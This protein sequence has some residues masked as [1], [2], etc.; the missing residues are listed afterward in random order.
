MPKSTP[1]DCA[2]GLSAIPSVRKNWATYTKKRTMWLNKQ[3]LLRNIRTDD[4]PA[5]M[6]LLNSWKRNHP[7]VLHKRLQ[8]GSVLI[9]HWSVNQTLLFWPVILF[10]S[11]TY[12]AVVNLL[13]SVFNV[14]FL[15]TIL[16]PKR[17]E[18]HLECVIRLLWQRTIRTEADKI[19]SPWESVKNRRLRRMGR[20]SWP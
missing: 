16:S 11:P 6:K 7:K 17:K 18:S 4:Y 10:D 15:I 3:K 14:V 9:C 8:G 20:K 5:W 1:R 13:I 2:N 12:V 19:I